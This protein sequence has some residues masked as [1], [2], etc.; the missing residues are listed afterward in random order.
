MRPLADLLL[1]A[2]KLL[3]SHLV[4]Q[5]HEKIPDHPMPGS[6]EGLRRRGHHQQPGTVPWIGRYLGDA[7]LRQ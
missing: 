5:L 1:S 7:L 3:R 2:R 4:L 6:L